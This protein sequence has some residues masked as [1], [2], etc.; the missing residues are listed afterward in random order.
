MKGCI[1]IQ[2]DGKP[3]SGL[4]DLFNILFSDSP[5]FT[6]NMF[7]DKFV[8]GLTNDVPIDTG[9]FAMCEETGFYEVPV[10]SRGSM[11]V[12]C[13]NGTVA[14]REEINEFTGITEPKYDDSGYCPSKLV[15][16]LNSSKHED[17]EVDNDGNDNYVNRVKTRVWDK[18]NGNFVFTVA[19][20]TLSARSRIIVGKRNRDLYF[21]LVYNNGFYALVWTDE[22]DVFKSLDSRFFV[23]SMTPLYA[24]DV[25]VIHPLYM[26]DKWKKWRQRYK[27]QS[28][29]LM[30]VAVF[31]KYLERISR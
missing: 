5:V 3:E 25:L 11:V 6:G 21:H 28:G 31:E 4:S 9:A 17:V 29:H 24:H 26:I 20:I 27:A 10:P 12:T 23:Y 15:V 8:V 13:F 2:S 16:R 30:A 22:V 7:T 1:V 19:Y 14:N 18:M